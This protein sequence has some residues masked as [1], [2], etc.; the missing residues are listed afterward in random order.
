MRD[1]PEANTKQFIESG[2][3]KAHK[4]PTSSI[5]LHCKTHTTL[6]KCH[7]PLNMKMLHFNFAAILAAFTILTTFSKC[8]EEVHYQAN[9][10]GQGILGGASRG[11]SAADCARSMDIKFF[12]NLRESTQF[13]P[14]M[15][16]CMTDKAYVG[17]TKD[18]NCNVTIVPSMGND[19]SKAS[20]VFAASVTCDD[21]G[22]VYLIGQNGNDT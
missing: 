7:K 2:K 4:K 9:G 18:G 11:A 6:L 3:V 19:K 21:T 12:Q 14:D 10:C 13:K 17:S 22:A 15:K 16:A 8:Q 1:L 5:D 20:L